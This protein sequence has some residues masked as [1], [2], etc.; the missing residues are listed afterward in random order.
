MLNLTFL[1]F[2]FIVNFSE[3]R[4]VVRKIRKV[5]WILI[6]FIF[7]FGLVLRMTT[8]HIHLVYID[9]S[10]NMEVGKNMLLYGKSQTC[11]Y[12]GYEKQKCDV[13][14][15]MVGVQFIYAIS[16]LLF[17]VDNYV[18]INTSVIFGS[19]SIILMF[20]VGY[21]MCII[22]KIFSVWSQNQRRDIKKCMKCT[23]YKK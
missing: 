15:K 13:Y 23:I 7:L 22:S 8:P 18:A 20:L 6:F 19:L 14:R 5:S 4:K 9:E 16:F 10:N 2:L 12:T 21:L 17:G 11:E 3:I 1:V